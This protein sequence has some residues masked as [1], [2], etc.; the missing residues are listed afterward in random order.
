MKS[1]KSI[2]IHSEIRWALDILAPLIKTL[3]SADVESRKVYDPE[4]IIGTHKAI[5]SGGWQVQRRWG[6]DEC[7]EATRCA[8]LVSQRG[9]LPKEGEAVL[10]AGTPL[11]ILI[12]Q[13]RYDTIVH[14]VQ[15]LHG[16][17]P[18][19]IHIHAE[20]GDRLCWLLVGFDTPASNMIAVT[21]HHYIVGLI[22]NETYCA[23]DDRPQRGFAPPI[24]KVL[25]PEGKLKRMQCSR[26][27]F[28]VRMMA[29]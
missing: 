29:E 24:F 18:D 4:G 12:K 21:P 5:H 1:N 19:L 22:D 10:K 13:S 6:F 11:A 8:V 26:D 14:D 16:S 23:V 28:E 17:E 20:S 2:G 15:Q 7:D 27:T 3:Q 25:N 9:E